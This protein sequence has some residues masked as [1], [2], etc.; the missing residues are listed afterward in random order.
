MSRVTAIT[1][2]KIMS[3]MTSHFYDPVPSRHS[4]H[5]T[6][7]NESCYDVNFTIQSRQNSDHGTGVN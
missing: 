2:L 4:D 1:R 3:R 7:N 6:G 5:G